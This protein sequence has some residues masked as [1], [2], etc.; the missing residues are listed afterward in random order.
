[1]LP[2]GLNI[3][4]DHYRCGWGVR[5]GIFRAPYRECAAR[6][7]F[8]AD[9]GFYRCKASASRPFGVVIWASVRIAPAWADEPTAFAEYQRSMVY[10]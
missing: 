6:W 5:L 7:R 8:Y 4:H 10:S 3:G 9:I 1:M 2:L